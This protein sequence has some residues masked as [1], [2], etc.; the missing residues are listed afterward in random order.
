[1][2][3]C[4][5]GNGYKQILICPG[6]ESIDIAARKKFYSFSCVGQ[7]TIFLSMHISIILAHPHKQSF[8][9]AIAETA[10][11]ACKH[12]GHTI[13]FHD[14]YAEKFNPILT[15]DEMGGSSEIPADIAEH[16]KQI[17]RADGIIVVHPNWWGQPPAIL[18]GWIDRVLREGVAYEFAKGDNGA[19]VPASLL[20]IKTALVFNTSN[21]P[22][23][24]EQ[25]VFRD[26][27]EIL[28]KQCV[29]GVCRVN[30][31]YR[32]MLSIV[33][34]SSLQQ[35]SEWLQEINTAVNTYF[36]NIS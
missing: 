31:F 29:F 18:K 11:F 19:G 32:R 1:M 22:A 16:C 12:N 10:L 34:S 30:I 33:V 9:H 5:N 4:C 24:R 13:Y 8:N 3:H 23:D 14:L 26:P 6:A 36:P 25:S 27:L 7:Q 28:W 17:S 21:T 2:F 20:K 35:R 15:V